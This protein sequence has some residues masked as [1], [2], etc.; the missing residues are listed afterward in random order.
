MVRPGNFFLHRLIE[1]NSTL[2]PPLITAPEEIAEIRDVFDLDVKWSNV[3]S[4]AG[5]HIILARDGLFK[6]IIFENAKIT[7]T[8]IRIRNLDYSTYFLKISSIAKDGTEGPF[9]D[10]TVFY[11]C[12]ASKKRQSCQCQ[13]SRPA[14]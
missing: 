10:I 9:S 8:F 2:A 14:V 12:S 11:Y 7:G 4:A 5:Y 1:I 3:P 6:N 13:M